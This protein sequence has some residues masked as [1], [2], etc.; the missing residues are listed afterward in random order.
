MPY[1]LVG[2]GGKGEGEDRNRTLLQGAALREGMRQGKAEFR[3][4]TGFMGPQGE[5][6]GKT[7]SYL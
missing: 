3:H 4:R 6:Y 5:V 2:E 7:F 1:I